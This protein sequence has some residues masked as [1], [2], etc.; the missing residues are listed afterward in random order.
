MKF[1]LLSL[2]VLLVVA[3]SNRE[4]TNPLDPDNPVTHGAPTGFR[5]VANRDTARLSWDPLEVSNLDKYYIYR[6]VGKDSLTLYSVVASNT[7]SFRDLKLTYDIS[8]AYALQAVTTA[9]ESR[10]T[11]PDTVIPGPVNFWIADFY[12]SS[13][14]RIS[15]DGNHVLDYEY[16]TSPEAVAFQPAENRVW[17]A[18]YYDRAL[19]HLNVDF[20]G[21]Q[22]VDLTGPPVEMAPNTPEGTIYVLQRLPDVI[23]YLNTHGTILSTLE[24]P[25]PVSINGS[26]AVDAARDYLWFS[27]PTSTDRGVIYRWGPLTSGG[28]WE[29][30]ARLAYP[31]QIVAEPREGGCW[32]ATDSGVVRIEPTGNRHTYLAQLQIWDISLNP[33]TGDCYYV[34]RSHQADSWQTGRLYG[35]P[36]PQQ[37]IILGDAF[38]FL[39]NIQVLPGEG[40][41]GFLVYQASTG[42]ILR[43]DPEANLIGW[44]KGFDTSLELTLE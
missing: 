44:R 16:F 34:G 26:L 6:C 43:F 38:P 33:S 36:D 23:H 4:R 15:Y 8:Y 29:F 20:S 14:W 32:V 39:V 35:S 30:M 13:V 40:R 37:E 3:C 18:D 21:I 10:R 12:G 2:A 11:P 1:A 41:V 27:N 25:S 5:A 17:V 28:R 31:R 22:R 7:T 19:Y 42:R 9:G 24:V